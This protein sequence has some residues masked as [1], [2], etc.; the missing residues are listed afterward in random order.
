VANAACQAYE[1]SVRLVRATRTVTWTS[2]SNATGT[3]V[4][5]TGTRILTTEEEALFEAHVLAATYQE[6]D[7]KNCG[8]DG[9]IFAMNVIAD[10]GTQQLY[11]DD[12]VNC[13]TDGRRVAP[14]VRDLVSEL[15]QT[16][17]G[18]PLLP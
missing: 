17:S 2:C 13:Y 3:N 1:R 8:Y 12:N 11:V 9:T 5:A 4:P 10:G 14:D 16:A 6:A 15:W 18:T 7:G